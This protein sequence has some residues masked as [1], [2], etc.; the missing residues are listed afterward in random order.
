MEPLDIHALFFH[1]QHIEYP[2]WFAGRRGDI[3]LMY[4]T[5]LEFDCKENFLV[6]NNFSPSD[7][8]F[9]NASIRINL[10]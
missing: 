10:K 8:S 3:F 6:Y 1:G 2:K 4:F 9:D 7:F 5:P